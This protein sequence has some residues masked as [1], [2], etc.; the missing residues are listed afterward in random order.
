M[1]TFAMAMIAASTAAIDADFIR[2]CQQGVFLTSDAQLDKFECPAVELT[3][4][5]ETYMNMVKP[6]IMMIENMN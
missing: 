2:G 5:V 4:Q 3:P 6:G 1:K